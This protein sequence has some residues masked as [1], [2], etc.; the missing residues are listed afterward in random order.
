ME[1]PMSLVSVG[2][3]VGMG[4]IAGLAL[5]WFVFRRHDESAAVLKKKLEQLQQDHHAYQE[6]VSR[7]FNQ[8]EQLVHGL[9][10]SYQDIQAHLARGAADLMSPE[11]R[12]EYARRARSIP[13]MPQADQP[14]STNP[15]L[16][17][18][19]A[20]A[21]QPGMLSEGYGLSADQAESTASRPGSPSSQP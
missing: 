18:A 11:V 10:R 5:G 1:S 19:P 2:L 16:D 20:A 21:E 13:L 14:P 4:L 12:L 17:Y 6:Q 3:L 9:Q 15:P 8:T 7:H